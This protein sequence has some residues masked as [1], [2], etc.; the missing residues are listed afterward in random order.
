MRT[1]TPMQ[2]VGESGTSDNEAQGEEDMRQRSPGRGGYSCHRR[3]PVP[4]GLAEFG[5]CGV[6]ELPPPP[7][8]SFLRAFAR[9]FRAALSAEGETWVWGDWGVRGWSKICI[10]LQELPGGGE[11]LVTL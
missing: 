6:F 10:A 4:E 11:G 7:P 2:A 1:Q 3:R 8:P 5:G 9:T